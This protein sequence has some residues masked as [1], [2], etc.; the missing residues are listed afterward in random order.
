MKWLERLKKRWNI[1]ESNTALLSDITEQLY[2]YTGRSLRFLMVVTIL[3]TILLSG[4]VPGE[5]LY[6]WTAVLSLLII[7]RLYDLVRFRNDVKRRSLS[8][9]EINRWYRTF[10]LKAILTAI[11]TG[12]SAPLFLPYLSS[13]IYLR[14]LLFF[15]VIGVSAGALAALF[16]DKKLV[17]VYVALINLPFFLYLLRSDE[18]YALITAMV[19]ILFVFV[20]LMIAQTSRR[21]FLR[22]WE[23]QKELH[24]KER[25]LDALFEQTPTPIFYFD[26]DLRI[27]KFNQAFQN[28][29]KVPSHVVLENFDLRKLQHYPAIK[30]MEKLLET[31]QPTEYRGYYLS[32]FNPDEYWILAK[33]APLFNEEGEL[34][35]GIVSFQDKTIEK[36]SIDHLERLASHDIL[37]DLGNRRSFYHTLGELVETNSDKERPLSLLFFIDLDRFKPINDTLGHQT[38]DRVLRE[39]GRL[40]REITPEEAK[41]FRHGGD[42]FI[43]LLPHCCREEPEAR[44]KGESFVSALEELLRNRIVIDGYHLPMQGSVGIVVITPEMHDSDEIIRRAD[45]SM[46]QAKNSSRSYAFYDPTMD[47]A[48]QKTFYLHQGLNREDIEHQLLLEYQPI[49]SLKE[50]RIRGAEALIRWDHPTLGLLGPDE[51]IPLAVEN[52]EIGRV[53]QWVARQVCRTLKEIRGAIPQTPLEYLSFN[54]DARE[55][56]YNDFAGYM[57]GLLHEHAIR[58]GELVLEI[59]ENSLIDN[60]PQIQEIIARL[61]R[62]GVCW[63]IDDF[64]IGY[65][66]L[67]YLERL[68]FDILKIDRSFTRALEKNEDS[69]F[70]VKHILEI[71]RH[72]G[73]QVTIEGIENEGQVA[74]LAPFAASLQ[75]QGFYYSRPLDKDRFFRLLEES[76]ERPIPNPH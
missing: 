59:T 52:G 61:H 4:K 60:F 43:V 37:T 67:S 24:A 63:A 11:L 22:V 5:V 8:Q 46:Y 55:L 50:G 20:L 65:S 42:E 21:F 9:K 41:V 28:F 58:P 68:S 1:E 39:V 29:F 69:L 14:F 3:L 72:L 32:T 53:G 38:G 51:F 73:Y 48:R 16:P 66:S 23:Q 6:P 76:G 12:M 71:A 35:G 70:L 74:R 2:L 26:T 7:D 36:Q 49:V 34:I 40:L 56:N 30:M 10:Y 18:P 45:I 64:G 19:L 54:I 15:F 27:R 57:E 33:M 25:E 44:A 31:K 75:A 13:E 17:T 47:H 62:N